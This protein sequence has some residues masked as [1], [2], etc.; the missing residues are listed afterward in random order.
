MDLRI[1]SFVLFLTS[2]DRNCRCL[3]V[4]WH[5]MIP[6]DSLAVWDR[7]LSEG[8]RNVRSFRHRRCGRGSHV[9][10]LWALAGRTFQLGEMAYSRAA[11]TTGQNKVDASPRLELAARDGALPP[12]FERNLG[13]ADPPISCLTPEDTVLGV[14][15]AGG[16]PSRAVTRNSLTAGENC[17]RGFTCL[18]QS[19]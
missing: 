14:T 8:I 9:S 7:R 13:Q 18:F 19:D 10:D 16:R 5:L 6:L 11:S 12:T 1:A 4:S 3:T 2:S 17:Q 15:Q